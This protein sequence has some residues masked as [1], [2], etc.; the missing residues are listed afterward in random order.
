MAKI[1]YISGGQ[2]SGKSSTAQILALSK[3]DKPIYVATAFVSD[4]EMKARIERHKS[5][6]GDNWTSI[7]ET[8][9]IGDLDLPDGSVVVLD[10]VTLWLTSIFFKLDEDVDKSLDFFK[11]QWCKLKSKN[12]D[13]IVVSNEIGMGVIPSSAMARK[14]ADLQGW[15]NQ[16]IARDANEAFLMVSGLKMK[17]K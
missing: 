10:C 2:R 15:A 1:T 12:I 8:L 17:I 13:L 3:T 4:D 16:I 14:F 11:E 9:Y 7:E 5:D 6:R